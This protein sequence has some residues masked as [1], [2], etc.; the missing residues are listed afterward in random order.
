MGVISTLF[1]PG[2]PQVPCFVLSLIM[3]LPESRWLRRRYVLYKRRHP[4]IFEAIESW[5]RE[6]RL[7]RIERHRLQG[8]AGAAT[9]SEQGAA[10]AGGPGVPAPGAEEAAGG[11]ALEAAGPTASAGPALPASEGSERAPAPPC[12]S[13][14][15]AGA[16]SAPR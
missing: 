9:A 7:A 6:R 3:I 15:D 11:G 14:R 4:R 2:L 5:R 12:A 1:I 13:D 10:A 16:A 8:G